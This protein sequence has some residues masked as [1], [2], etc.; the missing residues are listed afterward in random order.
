[1]DNNIY[2]YNYIY[3]IIHIIIIYI[4]ILC[5]PPMIFPESTLCARDP[6]RPAGASP[7]S[8]RPPIGPSH[9]QRPPQ[10]RLGLGGQAM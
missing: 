6:P 5:V 9:R 7:E 2:I 1:M 4:Y 8:I 10:E 3:I